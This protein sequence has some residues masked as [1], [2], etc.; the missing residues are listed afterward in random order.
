MNLENTKFLKYFDAPALPTWAFDE[1]LRMGDETYHYLLHDN[2]RDKQ[3]IDKDL[4]HEKQPVHNQTSAK[5]D[6]TLNDPNICKPGSRKYELRQYIEDFFK[7]YDIEID[8]IAPVIQVNMNTATEKYATTA[9]HCDLERGASI[10]LL[11]R[12]GGDDIITKWWNVIHDKPVDYAH[13]YPAEELVGPVHEARIE[14]NKWHYFNAELPHS[15]HQIENY[16]TMLGI[17]T[18]C[19]H[20][21]LLSKLPLIE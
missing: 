14:L 2:F 5:Y 15:I 12:K 7:G 20:E 9:A 11:I 13:C 18:K 8:A 1:F 19:T 4:W 3:I 10:N 6:W 17:Q 16:R 21:E